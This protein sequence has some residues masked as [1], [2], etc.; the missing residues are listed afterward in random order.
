MIKQQAVQCDNCGAINV[1][2]QEGT[3]LIDGGWAF[4][5]RSFGYYAGFT[6]SMF[7]EGEQLVV[8]CHDCC[9]KMVE[10]LPVMKKFVRGGHPSLLNEGAPPCCP[11]AWKFEKNEAG[12]L[13]TYLATED[14]RWEKEST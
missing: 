8:L 7:V 1:A 13:E 3:P 14:G 2:V 6:D 10:A 9:L 4:D 11:Y 5:V 12:E